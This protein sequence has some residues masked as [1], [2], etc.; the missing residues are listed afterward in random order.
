MKRLLFL[1]LLAPVLAGCLG[2]APPVPRDHYYRLLVPLPAESGGAMLLPGVLTVELL[3]ADGLLRERP[4]LYSTAADAAELQ[5]HNYHYWNDVPPRLL[6]DQMVTYL[7]RS[8]VASLVVTPDTRVRAEYQISGKAKRFERL[9]G[10]GGSKVVVEIEFALLRF[11]DDALL[12]VDTYSAEEA[13][14]GD[15]IEESILALNRATARV[16]D[17]FLSDVRLAATRSASLIQR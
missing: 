6:Q 17:A 7:R 3:Q 1:T 8:G 16:F 10:G 15:S 4:L 13:A 14:A 11:S 12:V 9:V 2:S 5:Q